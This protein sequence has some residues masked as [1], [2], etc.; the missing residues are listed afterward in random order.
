[1]HKYLARCGIGSRR[2][3]EGYIRLGLVQ[4]NGRA[5]T[6]MGHTLDP[7]R[8]M[9]RFKGKTVKPPRRTFTYILLNKPPGVVT[10]L[11]DEKGRPTVLDLLSNRVKAR[12]Y[13]VG[14]LDL[15]SAGLLLL[16]DDGELAAR[17]MHPRGGLARVYRIKVKGVPNEKA[18]ARLERGVSYR[19]GKSGRATARLVSRLKVNS[20]MEIT[21]FEG[22][23]REVRRM[24]ESVG[25]T[26][27]D[28]KRI[29][30]GPL[31]LGALPSGKW[32]YLRAGEVKAL[33]Q[34]VAG[35]RVTGHASKK[36]R[37][38]DSGRAT[39]DTRQP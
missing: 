39:R 14:R 12:V 27:V 21:L 26:V 9:V 24:L 17:L 32:R 13:P 34:A 22:R 36:K 8:D 28:L 7:A 18:V 37:R 16:T 1:M 4:V 23:K 2:K 35:S 19:G 20:F 30:F 33:Q 38:T 10:T 15:N 31:S 6:A 5:V 29:R 25:H 11:S 3:C